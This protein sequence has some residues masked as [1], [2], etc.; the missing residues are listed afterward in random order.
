MHHQAYLSQMD[1]PWWFDSRR[2]QGEGL[3]FFQM[4]GA[5]SWGVST[6]MVAGKKRVRGWWRLGLLGG[7]RIRGEQRFRCDTTNETFLSLL[8]LLQGWVWMLALGWLQLSSFLPK[9]AARQGSKVISKQVPI[10]MVG[11]IPWRSFCCVLAR[12]GCEKQDKMDSNQK[13]VAPWL[14]DLHT[15]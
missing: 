2:N 9:R 5:K 8:I 6:G 12:G 10:S 7:L 13:R 14:W 11:W 15:S 4:S 3:F 1:G